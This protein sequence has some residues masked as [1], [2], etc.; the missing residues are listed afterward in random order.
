[1]SASVRMGAVCADVPSNTASPRKEDVVVCD[2]VPVCVCEGELVI[3]TVRLWVNE[4]VWV[5]LLVRDCVCDGVS[6]KVWL[7]LR[8]CDALPDWLGENVAVGVRVS[9]DVK[10]CVWVRL[11]VVVCDKLCVELGVRD[12]EDVTVWLDE[13]DCVFEALEVSD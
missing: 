1:M 13:I 6:V 12:A 9:L 7:R 8:V 2:R 11:A 4:G 5:W 10:D 3:V